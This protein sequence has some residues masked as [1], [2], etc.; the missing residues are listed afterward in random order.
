M[1]APLT[2]P[3]GTVE[4][5]RHFSGQAAAA[6]KQS[7]LFQRLRL[8]VLWNSLALA[9]SDSQLRLAVILGCSAVIWACV[10]GI[11]LEGFLWLARTR[12]PLAG[13]IV[14]TL[15][16]LMFVA[17]AVLLVFSSGIIQYASLFSSPE[18]AYLLSTPARADDIFAYKFQG[19]VAFSSWAFVLL[20]SPVLIAYGMA[21]H[22]PWYF[23]A[24][25]P[26]YFLGFVLVPGAVGAL[27]CLLM[28]NFLPRR[29]KQV[30]AAASVLVI[31]CLAY[32]A[33][34]LQPAVWTDALNRDFIQ[35]LVGQFALVQGPLSPNHWL[36]R[37]LQSAARGEAINLL[38]YLA[39]LWSNGLLLYVLITWMSRYLYRRGFDR[40]SSGLSFRRRYGGAWIDRGLTLLVRF[41]DPRTRL[42]IV[43]DFR[44]FRRDPAQ[45]AQV[46]IFSGLIVLYFSNMHRFYQEDLGLRYQSAVSLL[47]LAATAL[48]LCSYTG[49]FIFPMLSLEGRKFWIL[50]LLPLERDRLL[51]GKFAFSATWSLLMA[52]FLVLFSDLMLGMRWTGI[53]LH[54]VIVAVLAL[55]FSGLSVG[56][57]ARMPNF[58]ESDPSKIAVGFG[59]TLNLIL[60]LL[61]MIVVLLLMAV[62]WHFLEI[63]SIGDPAEPRFPVPKAIVP[64]GILLG[65]VTGMVA[66][67]VPLRSGA[68]ALRRMEF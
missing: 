5:P 61:F 3:A 38:Y 17:L 52:E 1:T 58:R 14:G 6:A 47:N 10:F 37:G 40:M 51:W 4:A 20:G 66:V 60:C 13:G 25:L 55:G 50:G 67:L 12:I 18:S 62:P 9:R 45:W 63:P 53:A 8:R 26:L 19:A 39:L 29:P 44:T 56:L 21:F 46:L 49:R 59:G 11:S 43:K 15:F 30:L 68:R 36:S 64:V 2:H 41:L 22:V 23:Y 65:L 32:W 57:G 24:L 28:V 27:L 35:R 48:L 16:D 42:L 54:T 7:F 31:G 33:Y 34:S